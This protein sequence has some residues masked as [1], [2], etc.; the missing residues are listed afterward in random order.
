MKMPDHPK[1]G[2]VDI[3]TT[4]AELP[5]AGHPTIGALCY[6]GA[7]RPRPGT[8]TG[9]LPID[10]RVKAGLIAATYDHNTVFSTAQ[11][12]QNFHIHHN[13]LPSKVILT[14]QRSLAEFLRHEEDKNGKPIQFPLVSIVNG[15]TFALVG[16]P[17]LP[18]LNK[19][20]VTDVSIE[21]ACRDELDE[22]WKSGL[23]APY[24]FVQCPNPK[25]NI[26]K[27]QTRMIEPVFGEDPATG[28]AACA[29]ACYLAV[30]GFGGQLNEVAFEFE[31]GVEMGR[32]S[33]I[34]VKVTLDDT[35]EPGSRFVKNVLLEGQAVKVMEG[36]INIG[37]Q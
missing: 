7:T 13:S 34:R 21:D 24:Y 8:L 19:L 14:A 9:P 3:F 23:I 11:I 26:L 35:S 12:P 31:Q 32:R 36:T 29:L 27:F 17:S 28:S 37:V 1:S 6:I 20:G 33:V 30:R 22:G 25:D 10:L 2:K 5:F 16:V 15:M 18:H 4:T